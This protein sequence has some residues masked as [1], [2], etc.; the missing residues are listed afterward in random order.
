MSQLKPF[1]LNGVRVLPGTGDPV[2]LLN[3]FPLDRA[4]WEPLL[5]AVA[6]CRTPDDTGF[7]PVIALD[8]P[9]IGETPLPSADLTTTPSLEFVADAAV[10]ALAHFGASKATWIGCSMGGY[11]AMAIAERHPNAVAG[12]GLLN[13]RSIADTDEAKAKRL[14]IA[15]DVETL[16][17]A[18]DPRAMA[19]ALVGTQG[20]TREALLA[21]VAE[22][23]A[24]HSGAGIAWGQRAMAARPDRTPVLAELKVPTI[25]IAGELD[26]LMSVADAEHM[27]KA[28][29]VNP[30]VLSGIGHL[31]ALEA[32]KEVAAALHRVLHE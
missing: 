17:G 9:G 7:A 13:T 28:L 10:A 11:V 23:I 22:N 15:N 2:V 19:E 12:L 32:P 21:T 16:P 24:R 29:G 14:A 26:G 31:S 27:S 3:A 5:T 4:Q 20:P 8:M 18:R 1:A 6:E 25:V 30:V